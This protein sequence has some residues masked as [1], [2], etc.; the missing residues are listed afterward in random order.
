MWG[1]PWFYKEAERQTGI[2]S[3]SIWNAV[4]LYQKTC[5]GYQWRFND[6]KEHL[7]TDISNEKVRKYKQKVQQINKETNEIIKIYDS[8]AEASRQTKVNAGCIRNVCQGKSITAG[9]YKWQ[10]C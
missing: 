8:A 2:S 7:V 6:D 5:G 4:H 3:K 10:Y 9:G 1:S